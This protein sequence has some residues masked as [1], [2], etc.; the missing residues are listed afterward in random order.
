MSKLVVDLMRLGI[1]SLVCQSLNFGFL[2]ISNRLCQ[3]RHVG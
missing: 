1:L 2:P 3:A